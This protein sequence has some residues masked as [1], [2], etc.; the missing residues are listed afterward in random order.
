MTVTP[1]NPVD[2]TLQVAVLTT[3]Q[4]Q[5]PVC[6]DG[7]ANLAHAAWQHAVRVG[8]LAPITCHGACALA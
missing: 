1:S 5:L 7:S 8:E 3:A 2:K 4:L 6:K